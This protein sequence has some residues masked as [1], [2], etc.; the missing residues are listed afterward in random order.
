MKMGVH[1][2]GSNRDDFVNRSSFSNQTCKLGF[3]DSTSTIGQNFAKENCFSLTQAR[4]IGS[5]F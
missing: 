3:L 2:V 4:F 5:D 1:P